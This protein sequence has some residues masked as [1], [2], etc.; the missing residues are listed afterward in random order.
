MISCFANDCV[1]GGPAGAW[2]RRF[3]IRF[4]IRTGKGRKGRGGGSIYSLGDGPAVGVAAEEGYFLRY[5][6]GS[7]SR[8]FM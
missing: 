4:H 7:E 6:F 3:H 2:W 1:R 5:F 8:T